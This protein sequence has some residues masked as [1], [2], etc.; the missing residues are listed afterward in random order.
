MADG[1][2][3]VTELALSS[4]RLTTPR[5]SGGCPGSTVPRKE[6][7]FRTVPGTWR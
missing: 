6:P 7:N 1:P 5:R 3:L 2:L 4:K